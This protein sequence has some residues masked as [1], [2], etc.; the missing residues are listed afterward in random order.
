MI[1]G[2]GSG[3]PS[4]APEA[5]RGSGRPFFVGRSVVFGR[6]RPGAGGGDPEASPIVLEREHNPN[7]TKLKPIWFTGLRIGA[8]RFVG[9]TLLENA[10][11]RRLPGWIRGRS[12]ALEWALFSTPSCFAAAVAASRPRPRPRRRVLRHCT[13]QRSL[14]C[15]PHP[16]ADTWGR[17]MPGLACT[18]GPG[19]AGTWV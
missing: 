8:H 4:A 11:N 14:R 9:P 2:P 16:L 19:T 10:R 7:S 3:N 13:P 6:F 12:G 15:R 5:P 17:G 1:L 18:R